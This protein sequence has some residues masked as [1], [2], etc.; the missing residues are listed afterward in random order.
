MRRMQAV[1]AVAPT[2][3]DL[4]GGTV[5]IWPLYLFHPGAVTVN[6]AIDLV[7]RVRATPSREGG[8]RLVDEGSGRT[9]VLGGGEAAGTDPGSVLFAETLRALDACDGLTVCFEAQA[10]RGAG[11]AG[12]SA[13][14]V[15][16]CGAILRVKNVRMSRERLVGVAR[17]IETRVIGVPAGRQDYYPALWGGVQALWWNE[18]SVRREKLPVSTRELERR[19][20]LVYTG[21][22]RHSGANNWEVFQRHMAGDRRVR[23]LFARI[24][25]AGQAMVEALRRGDGVGVGEALALDATARERLFPG[26]V[27]EEIRSLTRLLRRRGALAA[28]VCGAGGGG[29][30]IV[31]ADPD[32]REALEKIVREQ[33]HR[34]LPFRIPGRGLRVHVRDAK[35]AEV[36]GR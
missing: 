27:T 18:G 23:G 2:R 32:R 9:V 13:M 19:L 4:A 21:T 34:P 3:I 31:Y 26:I 35:T 14:L 29:C 1:E 6:A 22:S 33:G 8:V 5:D 25:E 24:V 11:L 7:A 30:V 20:L 12:S 16:A 28:K 36:R 10:P 17:D 15:A